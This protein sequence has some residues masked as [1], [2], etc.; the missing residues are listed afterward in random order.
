MLY[1][2][3]VGGR[4]H[5][6]VVA[7]SP[8]PLIDEVLDTATAQDWQRIADDLIAEARQSL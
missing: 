5:P 7:E 4:Y 1:D 8:R 2:H 6:S 3:V